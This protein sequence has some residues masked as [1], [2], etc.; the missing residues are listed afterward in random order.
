MRGRHSALPADGGVSDG[1][2]VRIRRRLRRRVDHHVVV[3]G[4]AVVVLVLVLVLVQVRVISVVQLILR[5][6]SS[7]L[8]S[9]SPTLWQDKL[10][11]PH[12]FILICCF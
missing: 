1:L 11:C 5:T 12:Y 10:E 6:M 4:V 8:L 3:D 2:P 7:N 9:L